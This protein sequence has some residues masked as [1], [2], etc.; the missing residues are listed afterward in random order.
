[1]KQTIKLTEKNLHSIINGCVLNALKESFEDDYNK[2]RNNYKR[3]CWG[4]EMKT[5]KVIG[6]TVM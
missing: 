3:P 5:K 1:M 4:F 2:A 6:N